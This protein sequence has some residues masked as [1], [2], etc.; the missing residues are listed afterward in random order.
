MLEAV[1]SLKTFIFVEWRYAE[2]ADVP[3]FTPFLMSCANTALPT[4]ILLRAM[5]TLHNFLKEVFPEITRKSPR[6]VHM[7]PT[8]GRS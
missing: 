2:L 5:S 8:W 6:V 1:I 7:R 3:G 4:K